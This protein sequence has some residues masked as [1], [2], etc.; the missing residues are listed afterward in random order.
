MDAVPRGVKRRASLLCSK[1]MRVMYIPVAG[2]CVLFIWLASFSSALS[3]PHW[4]KWDRSVLISP[5][6][7]LAHLDAS[8][9]PP[10]P[11]DDISLLDPNRWPEFMVIGGDSCRLVIDAMSGHLVASGYHSLRDVPARYDIMLSY[12]SPQSSLYLGPSYLWTRGIWLWQ[13]VWYEPYRLGLK[14]IANHFYRSGRFMSF[15]VG[16]RSSDVEPDEWTKYQEY[17]DP[18]GR[19]VGCYFE[20]SKNHV[21]LHYWQGKRV[22][23]EVT[24]RQVKELFKRT[25]RYRR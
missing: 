13:R 25:E 24:R 2:S 20:S 3:H 11:V 6:Y 8:D 10:F 18:E 5:I 16:T 4:A 14:T 17:F 1:P 9:V 23:P 12:K 7:T 15:Y 19:L 22:T 21:A